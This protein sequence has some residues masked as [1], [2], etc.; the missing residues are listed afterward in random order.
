M[1]YD[2]LHYKASDFFECK[3]CGEC[4]M[5]YGGTAVSQKDI[6]KIAA[7][8]KVDVKSFIKNYCDKSG[9]RYM[10]TQREDGFCIF[11]DN[12]ICAIHPVKPKMCRDWPFIRNVAREPENWHIM[13]GM[14][15]GMKTDVP[16]ENIVEYINSNSG[17]LNY[18][19]NEKE[20]SNKNDNDIMADG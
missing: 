10:I 14:C 12:K 4:C 18:P 13:A 6:E 5:G 9:A 8:V 16:L 2:K 17:M 7:F 11:F 19:V 1:Q 20:R 3:Q 15:S